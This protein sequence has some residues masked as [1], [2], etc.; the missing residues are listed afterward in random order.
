MRGTWLVRQAS[1]ADEGWLKR[2][3]AD[4]QRVVL[5][6]SESS[7]GNYLPQE[8]FLLAEDAGQIKGFLAWAVRLPQ[9]GSLAA[10]GLADEVDVSFWLDHLLPPCVAHLRQGGVMDLSYTGSAAWLLDPLQE[11]GFRLISHIATF[12]KIGWSIPMAGN[13]DVMVRPVKP[14]DYGALV[15]LDAPSFHP[16][17]RNSM[18][19]L[20]RWRESLPYFVVATAADTVVGYCYCSTGKPGRGHLIRLAVHPAWWGQGIGT[21]LMAEAIL[22]F[23]RAGARH[24]T[25]NS[26]EENE[27]AQRLYQNFGFRLVGREATAL[28]R[29]L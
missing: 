21:R 25:L 9:Q 7:L 19:S 8:P 10:A 5:Q 15:A 29:E 4:A 27:R 14:A 2:L 23:Q 6:F 1:R 12:E 20:R 18:E 3:M 28:W 24:I 11:R 13:Q 17:W 22:Y 26:Q 16:R